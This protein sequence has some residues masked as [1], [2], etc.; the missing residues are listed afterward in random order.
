MSSQHSLSQLT[1][2]DS[3][4]MSR[5]QIRVALRALELSTRARS[6]GPS[7]IPGVSARALTSVGAGA[8]GPSRSRL[9]STSTTRH[10]Q[11]PTPPT[12]SQSRPPLQMPHDMPREDYAAPTM[13]TLSYLS[14]AIKYLLYG[15]LTLGTISLSAFEG[16]HLYI[17]HISLAPP[18]RISSDEYGWE[19]ETPSWT[20]GAKGGTD[21]RLG[22]RARHALRAAWICQEIGAG[23]AGS[24]G[25]GN[26]SNLHPTMGAI[27]GKV[28]Q[29]DR[30]YE[31]AEEYI[32]LAIREAKRKGLRFP[33]NLPSRRSAPGPAPALDHLSSSTSSTTTTPS[34]TTV[35]LNVQNEM[36]T[37]M[38]TS[39]STT[40]SI[41][42]DPTAID[43]LLL[44][45]GI[46]ER[47]STDTSLNQAKDIYE[48]VLS[49]RGSDA[50]A[51]RLAT[52]IG[53]L[54]QRTG[55][56]GAGWWKLALGKAGVTLP[57]AATS[58]SSTIHKA[59]LKPSAVKQKAKGWFSS[60][61]SDTVSSVESGS[62]SAAPPADFS[63]EAPAPTPSLSPPT[64][65]ATIT[66]LI[67]SEAQLAKD[68][69]YAQA[70]AV[71]DL[72][73]SL[74][75]SHSPTLTLV[76][77]SAEL[78]DLWLAHRAA[79]LQLHK[80]SIT[81]AQGRPTFALSQATTTAAEAALSSIPSPSSA[82]SSLKF[83]TKLLDRD[84]HL[85]AAEANYIKGI[86]LEKQGVTETLEPALES[87]ERAMSLSSADG[88]DV[89][90]EEWSRYWRSYARVKDKMD[91]LLDK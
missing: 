37:Q 50:R 2:R 64:L 12:P 73:L 41:E 8:A 79:L 89:K 72:A 86:L 69:H 6:L 24:I 70:G 31:L 63:A 54:E 91:K 23:G 18:S 17:E 21:S 55:G 83:A 82:S 5:P 74:V 51:M 36:Q 44:K 22:F 76:S 52:K 11:S 60:S 29:I 26:N 34:S 49:A 10:A 67:S 13:Y 14:R 46:L 62:G 43:L 38:Q 45:A 1:S 84:A 77:D 19:E 61:N 16:L 68:G 53:D 65:R 40:S 75:T 87:F 80:T 66:A 57:A 33:P 48:Q 28:N 35:P 81:Y 39:P 27:A 25:R 15:I 9:L 3:S 59:T 30:G 88:E 85:V 58:T 7:N 4:T 56:D 32:D 78:H 42:A 71:Q 90:G 20:G 47:I